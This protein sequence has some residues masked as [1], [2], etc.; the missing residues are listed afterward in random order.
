MF[1]DK[2]FNLFFPD[3]GECFWFFDNEVF[4]EAFFA[5]V[6]FSLISSD[7]LDTASADA[8]DS[9]M[10]FSDLWSLS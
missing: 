3:D 8:P 9:T 7:N 10:P 1:L 2:L 4:D 6:K 5:N